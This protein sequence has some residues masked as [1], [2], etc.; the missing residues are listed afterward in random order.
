MAD[1]VLLLL[2]LL[3]LASEEASN[4][5]GEHLVVDGGA[6][7]GVVR[8]IPMGPCPASN[9]DRGPDDLRTVRPAVAYARV[10]SATVSMCG[11]CGNMSTGRARSSR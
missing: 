9:R 4:I 11:V 6:T 7:L 2:L 10:K 5:T 3:L 8:E 1:A